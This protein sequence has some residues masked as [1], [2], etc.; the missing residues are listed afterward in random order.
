METQKDSSSVRHHIAQITNLS[1]GETFNN[2][3]PTPGLD[4]A[5]SQTTPL[6]GRISTRMRCYSVIRDKLIWL[7]WVRLR[8]VLLI[9]DSMSFELLNF[10]SRIWTTCIRFQIRLACPCSL[11]L[12]EVDD[13]QRELVYKRGKCLRKSK[14]CRCLWCFT[15]SELSRSDGRNAKAEVYIASSPKI[16][17]RRLCFVF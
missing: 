9:S 6:A 2:I 10:I 5:I 3:N 17:T 7:R 15:R 11:G 4:Y 12:M 1:R 8:F 16:F 13:C 14:G